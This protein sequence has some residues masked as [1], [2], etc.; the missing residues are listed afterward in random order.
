M[1]V[2]HGEVLTGSED[3]DDLRQRKAARTV[4]KAHPYVRDVRPPHKVPNVLQCVSHRKC[5]YE[6]AIQLQDDG[7]VHPW[8]VR[9][10]CDVSLGSMKKI[11]T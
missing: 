10:S 9:S 11:Q 7:E 2:V 6:I 8:G 1:C 4:G 3:R 5:S